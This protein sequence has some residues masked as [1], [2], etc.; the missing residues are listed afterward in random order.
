MKIDDNNGVFSS[1]VNLP[2]HSGNRGPDETEVDLAGASG[3]MS[4]DVSTVRFFPCQKKKPERN[5]EN[6]RKGGEKTREVK[7]KIR[8][9]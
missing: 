3:C 1:R 8:E 9:E 4:H 5:E 7:E 6:K 2:E